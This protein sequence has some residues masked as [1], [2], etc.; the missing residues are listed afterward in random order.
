VT[1]GLFFVFEGTEGSGKSTQLRL[2]ADCFHESGLPVLTTREPGGTPLGEAVRTILLSDD[3]GEIDPRTEALL[4][5]AARAEH[6]SRLIR[7]ALE[8]GVHVLSDRFFDSTLAYQGGGSGLPLDEL[9]T[10]QCF[11]IGGTEPDQRILLK[12]SVEI[13]LQR[14]LS[15]VGAINRVDRAALDYHE[16]VAATFISLAEQEPDRWIVVDGEQPPD[17]VSES[18]VSAIGNRYPDLGLR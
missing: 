4:H 18:V 17:A 8:T 3:Y 9:R 13:G 6:V 12:T 7:P 10:L 11:A 2:L 1:R 15:G 5:T 14:R 16:R